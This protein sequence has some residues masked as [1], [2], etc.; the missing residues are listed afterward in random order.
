MSCTP[1]RISSF[2]PGGQDVAER[3]LLSSRLYGREA[4]RILIEQ[5]LDEVAHGHSSLLVFSGPPGIG[6]SALTALAA[7]S[8]QRRQ[9]RFLRGKCQQYHHDRPCLPLG[10]ALAELAVETAPATGQPAGCLAG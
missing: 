5:T 7:Q 8:A 3:L 1:R 10:E 2:R 9:I 4:Q 6:K